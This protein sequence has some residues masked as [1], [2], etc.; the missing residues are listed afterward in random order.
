MA[1]C[2]AF[3]TS[4][5]SNQKSVLSRK[6]RGLLFYGSL[7]SSCWDASGFMAALAAHS[8]KEMRGSC[9]EASSGFDIS[10]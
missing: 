6:K 2:A 10:S 3:S 7:C 4:G 8:K 1:G 9:E 5:Q